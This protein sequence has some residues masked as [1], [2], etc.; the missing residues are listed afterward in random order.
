MPG[1]LHMDEGALELLNAGGKLRA[2][3]EGKAAVGSGSGEG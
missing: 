1:P 3:A 2:H